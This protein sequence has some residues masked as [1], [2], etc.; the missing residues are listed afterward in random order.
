MTEG[1]R[2][3]CTQASKLIEG[4]QAAYLLAGNGDDIIQRA[5]HQGMTAANPPSKK[6]AYDKNIYAYDI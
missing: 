5:Q 4:I 6:K 3:D 2:A 1:A